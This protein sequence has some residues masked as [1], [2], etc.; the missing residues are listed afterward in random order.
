MEKIK[1]HFI[2]FMSGRYGSDR[3]QYFLLTMY[4]AMCIVNAF[5]RSTAS[6][7]LSTVLFLY[8]FWRMMSRNHV[9]RIRENAKFLKIW[10]PTKNYFKLQK[11]KIKYRKDSRFRKCTHCHVVIKL[12]NKKGKHTVRCPKCNERF[13]V[14]ITF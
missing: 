1:N 11:D 6:Y 9:A 10:I 7:L 14:N 2:K 12:P 3:F 5:T 8:I 4:A 13:E